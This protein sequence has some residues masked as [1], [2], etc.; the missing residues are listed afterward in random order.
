MR[1]RISVVVK[2]MSVMTPRKMRLGIGV[3]YF[4]LIMASEFGKWPSRAPTKKR[5]D[6]AKMPPFR[7]PN[8]DRAT[9]NGIIHLNMPSLCSPKVTATAVEDNICSF[10]RTAKYAALAS[11]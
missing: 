8:V 7:P 10:E 2:Y 4:I 9:E 1:A 11:T 5:R 3:K 6:E